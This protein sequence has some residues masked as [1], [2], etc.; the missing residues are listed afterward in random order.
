M[1]DAAPFA[2]GRDADVFAIDAGRVLRRYR[3]GGDVAAEATVMRYVAGFGFPVPTVHHAGGADLVMDRV[4]GPTMA[5]AL[6]AG[7]LRLADAA[8]QLADLHHRLHELPPRLSTDPAAR[9]LH[10]DLHPQNVLLGPGGPVVIDW[11]NTTEGPP[12]LDVALSAVILAQVAVDQRHPWAVPAKA[13]LTEF[14]RQVGGSPL[15]LLEQAVAIR[16]ADPGLTPDEV[17]RLDEAA[18]LVSH[19]R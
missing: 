2:S 11:R 6:I 5:S 3:K 9:V 16:K 8:T 7:T 14:L 15:R 4:D 13:L 17:D 12:D 19:C 10:M 18:T 1:V